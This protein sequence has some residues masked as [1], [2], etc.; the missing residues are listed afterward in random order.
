MMYDEFLHHLMKIEMNK[1]VKK[2]YFKIL[3]VVNMAVASGSLLC[4]HNL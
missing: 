1:C 2:E 4:L 3:E